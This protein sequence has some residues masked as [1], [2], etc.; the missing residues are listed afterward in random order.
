MNSNA[1]LALISELYAQVAELTDEVHRLR[2]QIAE[3][4]VESTD[5]RA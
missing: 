5:A 1:I 4:P 2:S 3:S